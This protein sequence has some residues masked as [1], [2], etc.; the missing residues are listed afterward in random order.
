MGAKPLFALN[1]VG[2]PS[3]RLPMQVLEEILKGGQA[4]CK[5]AGIQVLGGHSV[6]DTEPK[7]G[8]AVIGAVHPKRIWRNNTLRAGDILVLTKPIGTGIL[9]T[10][11][12]RGQVEVATQEALHENMARLNK[13]AAECVATFNEAVGGV[14]DVTGFGFLGHLGEMVTPDEH[15]EV[16][17]TAEVTA[18]KVP[19]LPQAEEL[20]SQG[21]SFVPGGTVQN[22]NMAEAKGVVFEE[23]V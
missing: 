22:L 6:D 10:A 19:L 11:L 8:L 20:A 5:E 14:T 9:S 12:K 4:K 21:E 13:A 7:Y 2:F 18:S 17:V 15:A 3:H 1:I 16:T 23:A